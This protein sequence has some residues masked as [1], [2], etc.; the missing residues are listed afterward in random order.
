MSQPTGY[1]GATAPPARPWK[2]AI[3]G[4]FASYMDAA[5][6]VASGTAWVLYQDTFHL[7]KWSIGALSALITFSLAVG[8]LVGGRLGDRYGRKRVFS[9]DLLVFALGLAFLVFAPSAAF[10]YVGAVIAG[11]AM[12]ADI[13]V[14]LALI[15]EE[16]PPEKR[17]ELIAF[18]QVLWIAGAVAS[19][20]LA[21]LVSKLGPLGA[22]ILFSHILI[23]AI[24]I[25]LLRRTLPESRQWSKAV[26]TVDDPQAGQSQVHH[27]RLADL[28]PFLAPL[29]AT[30]L[31]Y[32]F[33]NVSANTLGQFST[34]LFVDVAHVSVT[35]ATLVGLITL[36]IVLI[37]NVIFMR[38]V[39]GRF[40]MPV[41]VFGTSLLVLGFIVPIVLGFRFETLVIASVCSAIGGGLAG[42]AI[43][44]VW[45]Q[46]LFPTL[47]R[48]SAQGST[49]FVA[50]A[51]TA[52]FGFVT[53]AIALAGP[54]VLMA[55]L[56]ALNLAA[57]VMG[58]FWVR[59][60]P[61]VV[62]VEDAKGPVVPGEV[63]LEQIPKAAH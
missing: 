26:E 36:P 2:T 1:P 14:S 49:I 47:V 50:R 51:A 52:A 7:G 19:V 29:V 59:R 12:G 43:Y 46:E 33:N 27:N 23:V 63:Q 15:A 5:T 30:A 57:G 34:F 45:S 16:S 3:L 18:S 25:W 21:V 24:V 35:T 31:F 6:I 22:R 58:Y 4:G 41:F 10:L 32:T 39:D 28:L 38:V 9:I 13:P 56:V 37:A 11:F 17:G 20:G 60:L 42:E 55:I 54:R 48:S 8:A 53:P 40:R 62:D 44:K 61:K